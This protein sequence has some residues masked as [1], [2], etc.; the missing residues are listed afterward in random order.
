M[1]QFP[2]IQG[3]NLLSGGGEGPPPPPLNAPLYVAARALRQNIHN[4]SLSVLQNNTIRGARGCTI[5]RHVNVYTYIA[6]T[7]KRPKQI[8]LSV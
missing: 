5:T 2:P 3:K 6:N 8:A 1:D 7:A 4:L